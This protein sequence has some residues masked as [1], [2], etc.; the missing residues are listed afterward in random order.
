MAMP[1]VAIVGRPNVG[2]SSLLNML[3]GRRVSIVEPT[4]GVTRDRVQVAC[5]HDG[6]YFDLVDTGGYGIVDRDDLSAEVERQIAVAVHEASLI[7][8]VVDGREGIT[9]LDREVAD[10]LRDRPCPML[11]IANKIDSPDMP[12]EMGE[13]T[14]LGLG[15][16]LPASALHRRGVAQIKSWI[17]AHLPATDPSGADAAPVMKM[18]IVGRRNAGKSSFINALAGQERTIVSE[19]PGTTRDAIDVRFELHGQQFIAIDTAGLRKKSRV[20]DDIE[21]YSFQR[22]EL[23]IRRADVAVLMMDATRDVGRVDKRLGRF[24]AEHYKPCIQ[25]VNKWDLAKGHASTDAYGQ[26]LLEMMPMLD[27]APVAFTSAIDGKNVQ[28]VIDLSASLFK[29]AR[30]R[31]ST[32]KLNRV[33]NM[34]MNENVPRPGKG[35]RPF[36][37]L[38]A[39]QVAACPPTL[40]LFVDNPARIVPAFERFLVHRLRDMLPFAEV[41]LRLVFRPRHAMQDVPKRTLRKTEK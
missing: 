4:A 32:G 1:I 11:L 38:Y 2:K 18:A 16:P 8:F 40:V 31:V 39:T 28:S 6:V 7:L 26:Y 20:T 25:V 37:I 15:E 34:I 17:V 36:K 23:S 9:P 41:P 19:I 30:A 35:Q 27:Y 3:V 22:A 10:W 33:V 14:R 13:L 24:I 21:Y 12:N 29:Q 5:E